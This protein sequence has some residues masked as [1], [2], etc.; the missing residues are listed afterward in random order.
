M[1]RYRNV[2]NIDLKLRPGFLGGVMQGSGRHGDLQH[3]SLHCC[4]CAVVLKCVCVCVCVCVPIVHLFDVGNKPPG[5]VPNKF[6]YMN[7]D[8]DRLARYFEVPMQAP[9]D[10][11]E[12]MFEKGK[13]LRPQQP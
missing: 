1:C 9:S 5:L 13:K 3:A 7:K 11:F 10:P 8:L 12:A 2:W 6:L 4:T